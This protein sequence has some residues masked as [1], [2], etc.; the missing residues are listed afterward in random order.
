MSAAVL[1]LCIHVIRLYMWMVPNKWLST[2]THIPVCYKEN[3]TNKS[4]KI[5]TFVRKKNRE[6]VKLK[7]INVCTSSCVLVGVPNVGFQ[8]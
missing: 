3:L 1:N 5:F 7:Q 2:V 6:E 8:S 4:L